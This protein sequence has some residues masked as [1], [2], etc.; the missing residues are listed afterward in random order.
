MEG[1]TETHSLK[2]RNKIGLRIMSEKNTECD[3]WH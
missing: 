3:D 1:Q 2:L